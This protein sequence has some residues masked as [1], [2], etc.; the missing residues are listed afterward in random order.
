[1]LSTLHIDRV[2][3]PPVPASQPISQD[4]SR[5]LGHCWRWHSALHVL[6]GIF[7]NIVSHE[8]EH[9]HLPHQELNSVTVI[10]WSFQESCL[11]V[12]QWHHSSCVLWQSSDTQKGFSM[13]V[14]VIKITSKSISRNIYLIFFPLKV[15]NCSFF[16]WPQLLLE[17]PSYFTY[18]RGKQLNED[19]SFLPSYSNYLKIWFE[20]GNFAMNNVRCHVLCASIYVLR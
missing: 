4:T 16:I 18:L 13:G 8:N 5:F 7:H 1:M 10:L 17:G 20:F 15:F 2:P 9:H 3:F 6:T 12:S 11:E 14:S 19:A